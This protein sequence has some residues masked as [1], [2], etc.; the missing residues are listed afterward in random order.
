MLSV[1]LRATLA[2]L[3][4]TVP[5]ELRADVKIGDGGTTLNWSGY[6]VTAENGT[7]DNVRGSWIQPDVKCVSG[8]MQVAAY[9]I[10]IDGLNTPSVEQ[11]GT[12]TACKNGK[13]THYA[14]F[15]FYPAPAKIIQT[16]SI[17]PGDRLSA[18][19][20]TKGQHFT[21]TLKNLTTGKSFKT[22]SVVADALK[23][24]AEWITEAPALP[25]G[26]GLPLSNF[27]SVTFTGSSASLDNAASDVRLG[28]LPNQQLTMVTT[29][30][31]L[32]ASAT[33]LSDAGR[34]FKVIWARH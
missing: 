24:S 29:A 31:E 13:A 33:P 10:G 18:E 3:P 9:W 22:S 7:F 15:E 11:V 30:G 1:V 2:R 12:G 28:S 17:A 19:I 20:T 14:W 32:R 4:E 25:N 5:P 27:G 16:I 6:A 8:E 26:T 21:I 23:S 34:K